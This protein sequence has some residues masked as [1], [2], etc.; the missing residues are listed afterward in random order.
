MILDTG[1][2]ATARVA[3]STVAL[4]VPRVQGSSGVRLIVSGSRAPSGCATQRTKVKPRPKGLRQLVGKCL[5]QAGVSLGHSDLLSAPPLW[6]P[7]RLA[8][9]NRGASCLLWNM[10]LA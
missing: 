10:S 4:K 7:S 9:H 1:I 2:V 5:L 3:L 6:S 8:R